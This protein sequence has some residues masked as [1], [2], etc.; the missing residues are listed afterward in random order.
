MRSPW[1]TRTAAAL[2]VA[3]GLSLV[4]ATAWAQELLYASE[5]NRL[6]RYDIDTLDGDGPVL[7]ELVFEN[8]SLDP[9]RGRDIN[10][11][12]CALPDGSGRFIAAEDSS[13]P[14]PPAGW[15]LLTPDGR[16]L[17]KL[18]PTALAEVPEPHG[19]AFDAEGRLFTTEV[20]RQ[21]FGGANGQLIVWFPPFDHFPGEPGEYPETD[22]TSSNYCK[23]ATDIGTAA[24]VAVDAEGRVYVAA[25]SGMEVLRFSPPF[26]TSA[27][28]QGGCGALDATGAPLADT[29]QR[30]RFLGPL[31]SLALLTYSGLAMTPSGNLYVASVVTGRIAEF[32]LEGHLVRRVLVPPDLLPPHPT[33]HPQGLAVDSRGS[34][35]YADLDL[36][37]G[38]GGVDTGPDGKVW[39]IRFDDQGEPLAPQLVARG[40]AFPDGLG[41]LPGDLEAR[42]ASGELRL[43]ATPST[44]LRPGSGTEPE[45]GGRLLALFLSLLALVVAGRLARG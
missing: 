19:C 10:G 20:G 26:P 25:A 4:A 35:Y 16:Q 17:G 21:F 28:A 18:T 13:Q 8:A 38:I 2:L 3:L 14:H 37:F 31:P 15:G 27:D 5:G 1:K 39:R 6:R 23:L 33:G 41:V 44:D 36:E 40:L 45:S 22:A 43:P 29:V 42:A 12:V 11:T 34:L 9:E 24:G 7:E 32:D 30:E